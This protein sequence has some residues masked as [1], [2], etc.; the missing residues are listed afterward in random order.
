MNLLIRARARTCTC[1]SNANIM[2]THVATA[3]G[4]QRQLYMYVLISCACDVIIKARQ[5]RGHGEASTAAA[6]CVVTGKKLAHAVRATS[7]NSVRVTS[8]RMRHY[9]RRCVNAVV[10]V[11]VA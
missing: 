10:A 7:S 3:I 8:L 1:T 11:V 5:V 4:R 2:R 6:G 9:R